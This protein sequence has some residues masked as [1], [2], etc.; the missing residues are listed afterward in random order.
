MAAEFTAAA[1]VRSHRRSPKG[2]GSWAFQR[3]VR[4]TAFD[5]ELFGPIEF[6]TGTLTE[7]KKAARA[8]GFTGLVAVLP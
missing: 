3:T 4:S 2:R 6:F 5:A 8:A 7:A 1:F